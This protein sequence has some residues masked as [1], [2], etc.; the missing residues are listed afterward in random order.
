[1]HTH[2]HT[3]SFVTSLQVARA[4]IYKKTPLPKD[5]ERALT[6]KL[7]GELLEKE[8]QWRDAEREKEREW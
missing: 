7:R 4:V 2:T 3:C 5:Q 1:M 6:E 8:R